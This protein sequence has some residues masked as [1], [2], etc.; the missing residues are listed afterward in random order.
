MLVFVQMDATKSVGSL[1]GRSVPGEPPT[2]KIEKKRWNPQEEEFPVQAMAALKISKKCRTWR[3]RPYDLPTWGQIK[4][5]TNQAENLVS[6]QRMPRN[7]KNIF[8]AMLVLLPPL[9]LTWLI[10]SFGLIY[11][12]PLYCRLLNGQ[13]WD[14]LY[15]LMTQYIC[16]LL[17]AWL[18]GPSHPE[19]E[20]RLTFL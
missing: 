14:R 6:Q 3:H 19:D 16:L 11:L 1:F 5:L 7:P 2:F 17:G 13:I 9:R 12:S 8:V 4:T 20:G 18:E 15:P 10:T